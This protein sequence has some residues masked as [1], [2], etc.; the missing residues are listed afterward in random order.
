MSLVRRR[1]VYILAFVV[2]AIA[3]PLVLAATFGYRWQPSIGI[4]KTGLIVVQADPRAIV[5]LNGVVQGQTPKRMAGLAPGSYQLELVRAG[6]T[7]WQ[8]VIAV[9][10]NVATVIGPVHLYPTLPKT[11]L[12]G[13]DLTAA[14]TDA[15][16]QH[17]YGLTRP[18]ESSWQT[19]QLWPTAGS[20]LVTAFQPQTIRESPHAQLTILQSETETAVFPTGQS[21]AS[22]SLPPLDQLGWSA[23]S[24]NVWFGLQ[25]GQLN[26]YD[27]Y[28]QTVQPIAAATSLSADQDAVWYTSQTADQTQLYRLTG[29]GNS[30]PTLVTTLDGDWQFVPAPELVVRE[31]SSRDTR[32]LS[33]T[34][35]TN[36]LHQIDFGRLDRLYWEPG[37]QAPLWFN[38]VDFQ[39][40]INGQVALVERTPSSY[41]QA[42]WLEP[43]HLLLT[44]DA[45]QVI[46]RSLSVRQGQGTAFHYPL[47]PQTRVMLVDLSRQ[48]FVTFDPSDGSLREVAWNE[49]AA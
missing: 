15:A 43:K 22:W 31:N 21:A 48:R 17:V 14:L 8:H 23:D 3:A 13:S 42:V 2:F 44:A 24:D 38:G 25:A 19:Q 18:S 5:R 4:T 35:L 29:T 26:Q 41:Q 45:D 6:Y 46:I 30:Q 27:A 16:H 34:S 33:Y 9:Q 20:R 10:P 11:T 12:L 40:S 47:S 49:P 39:T 7:S 36:Q 32:W 28:A 1:I 37:S